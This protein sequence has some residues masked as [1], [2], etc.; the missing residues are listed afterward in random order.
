LGGSVLTGTSAS[1]VPSDGVSQASGRAA[2]PCSSNCAAFIA[3]AAPD[4]APSTTAITRLPSRVAVATR[5][6]PEAQMKPV[7]IPSAPG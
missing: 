1:T 3:R 6:K 4:G 7:F 2:N 5:L